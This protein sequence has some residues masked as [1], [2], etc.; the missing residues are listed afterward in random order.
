MRKKKLVDYVHSLDSPWYHSFGRQTFRN[1]IALYCVMSFTV[2]H[3]KMQ[4]LHLPCLPFKKHTKDCNMESK[5]F[6]YSGKGKSTE[7]G[8]I[9]SLPNIVFLEFEMNFTTAKTSCTDTKFTEER[10][11]PPLMDLLGLRLDHR[12]NQIRLHSV[13]HH[14]ICLLRQLRCLLAWHTSH[15]ILDDKANSSNIIIISQVVGNAKQKG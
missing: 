1:C 5:Y 14:L 2:Q 15:G 7:A 13:P 6:I 12:Q 9:L 10:S 4:L 11:E 3:Y 8:E